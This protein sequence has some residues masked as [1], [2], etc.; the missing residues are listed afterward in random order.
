MH[1]SCSAGTLA[2]TAPELMKQSKPNVRDGLQHQ[3]QA[4][5]RESASDWE[6]SDSD[7]G[8][9]CIQVVQI[10]PICR[11]SV[12]RDFPAV[13]VPG[14][15]VCFT[16]PGEKWPRCHH[17]LNRVDHKRLQPP[18][19][20]LVYMVLCLLMREDARRRRQRSRY[21]QALACTRT[22][23]SSESSDNSADDSE[24][25]SRLT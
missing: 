7:S 25:G 20:R 16:L 6:E 12:S 1:S 2:Q 13:C 19:N 18:T 15:A 10:L 11:C 21:K 22:S 23:A 24:S 17:C 14:R 9:A 4:Q 5:G 8:D 3:P